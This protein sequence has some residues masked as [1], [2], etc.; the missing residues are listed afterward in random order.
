[1]W[2]PRLFDNTERKSKKSLLVLRCPVFTESIVERAKKRSWLF[3]LRPLIFF[4]A[5]DFSLLSLLACPVSFWTHQSVELS[6]LFNIFKREIIFRQ[7]RIFLC[8]VRSSE[9]SI[10]LPQAVLK[11]LLE[12]ITN[13]QNRNRK[14][15]CKKVGLL[16]LI[17]HSVTNYQ[18]LCPGVRQSYAVYSSTVWPFSSCCDLP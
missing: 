11:A 17:T 4:E 2:G 16:R 3:V 10:T 5:L 12:P 7:L 6:V 1:M 15:F 9:Q 13:K 8:F 18:L 14:A